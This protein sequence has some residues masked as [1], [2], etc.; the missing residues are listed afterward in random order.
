MKRVQ[1]LVL[2]RFRAG[3]SDRE[4]AG[5]FAELARLR[6]LIPGIEYFAGGP[7][8]SPEGL[9]EGFTHAFVMT[10]RDAAARDHYLPHPEHERVKRLILPHVE[11]VL[12][13]DCEE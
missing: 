8:M 9:G 12:V 2:V 3:V 4:I 11:K 1:H 5:F 6:Q 7:N 13:F 10:F